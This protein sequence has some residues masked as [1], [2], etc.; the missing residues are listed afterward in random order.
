MKHLSDIATKKVGWCDDKS[1]EMKIN[2]INYKFGES[3]NK[4]SRI[5]ALYKYVIYQIIITKNIST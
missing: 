3:E 5:N 4:P 2:D 1:N